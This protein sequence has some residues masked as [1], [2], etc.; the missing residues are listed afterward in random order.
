MPG[1]PD[2]FAS[3]LLSVAMIG[4]VV[5]LWGA[6]RM[7]FRQGNRQKGALM[8]VAALVLLGNLLIWTL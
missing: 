5:L 4:V 7:A 8:V 6:W 1:Q 2:A 3:A